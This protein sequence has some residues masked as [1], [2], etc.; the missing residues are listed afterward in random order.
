MV[1]VVLFEEL[2][3]GVVIAALFNL[4]F[5]LSHFVHIV[6]R[7]VEELSHRDCDVINSASN[8]VNLL[9][10]GGF[11]IR[12]PILLPRAVEVC[13]K[14]LAFSSLRVACDPSFFDREVLIK[15]VQPFLT[16]DVVREAVSEHHD[17]I[18]VFDALDLLVSNI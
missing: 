5:A 2:L 9:R 10:F 3:V 11:R 16:R 17:H 6:C 4:N 1:E 14:D 8:S 15:A 13:F 7:V 18:F 12:R